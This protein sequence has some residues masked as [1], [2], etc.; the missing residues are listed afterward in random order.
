MVPALVFLIAGSASAAT[1]AKLSD[2]S[3][4]Q[5][6]G[7]GVGP[8]NYAVVS[9]VAAPNG[10]GTGP[11]G[12]L[13]RGPS[14][15]MVAVR[16]KNAKRFGVPR[17]L[18]PFDAEVASLSVAETGETMAVWS[19]RDG[20]ILA[21][22]RRTN[23]NW[24][25]VMKIAGRGATASPDIPKLDIADD[26]TAIVGWRNGRKRQKGAQMMAMFRPG[27]G[28][29]D[30]KQVGPRVNPNI[31]APGG[32]GVFFAVSARSG[33]RGTVVWT[34][35]CGWD[36]KSFRSGWSVRTSMRWGATRPAKIPNSKCP[37]NQVSLSENEHGKAV[38]AING[39]L[40]SSVVRVAVR[41]PGEA[42][43]RRAIQITSKR[44]QSS[45][46]DVKAHAD[47]SVTLVAPVFRR[48]RHIGLIGLDF[49]RPTVGL[50]TKE[51]N[52]IAPPTSAGHSVG[53]NSRGDVA[54]LSQNVETRMWDFTAKKFDGSFSAS[55]QLP[56]RNFL[57]RPLMRIDPAAIDVGPTGRILAVTAR[58]RWNS[59]GTS[60][61]R[62]I[63]IFEDLAG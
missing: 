32:Q 36:T 57:G 27:R 39:Y 17:R 42:R 1:Q 9:W 63:Y 37:H 11:G 38:L 25:R 52:R 62:G 41:P 22:Y 19:N 3:V 45:F 16:S 4:R 8:G 56:F 26:G 47:G 14:R 59:A 33:G 34:S 53:A 55:A 61:E 49:V 35:S 5:L 13:K 60:G 15:V 28:F 10:V 21:R 23:G 29:Q 44:T 50:I 20:A 2:Q 58:A 7:V 31:E 43:F 40:E 54:V 46:A 24:S 48:N 18:S 12:A 6:V 30:P 51:W